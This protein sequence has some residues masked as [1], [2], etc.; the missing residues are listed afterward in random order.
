MLHPRPGEIYQSYMRI[1]FSTFGFS[2][3]RPHIPLALSKTI[4]CLLFHYLETSGP[5]I[6]LVRSF[7]SLFHGNDVD[8]GFLE[9]PSDSFSSFLPQEDHY[10][11]KNCELYSPHKKCLEISMFSNINNFHTTHILKD[12][13]LERLIMFSMFL[14][15]NFLNLRNSFFWIDTCSL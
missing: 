10:H 4:K 15:L 6:P 2:S 9:P 5:R 14:A 1:F 12:I 3:S 8:L 7:L 11:A 13:D